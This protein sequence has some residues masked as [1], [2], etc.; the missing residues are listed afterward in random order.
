LRV[1]YPCPVDEAG[2]GCQNNGGIDSNVLMV[3]IS[4]KKVYGKRGKRF[5]E[6]DYPGDHCGNIQGSNFGK[7]CQKG[8]RQWW[9][10]HGDKP[11]GKISDIW[12]W[13]SSMVKNVLS[14]TNPVPYIAL[15]GR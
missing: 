13:K 1:P 9:I 14:H 7:D 12:L 15:K 4:G 5:E 6:R 2:S 3:Q 11:I 8:D 10:P